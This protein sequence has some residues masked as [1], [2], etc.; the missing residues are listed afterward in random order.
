[1]IR[2]WRGVGA[3]GVTLALLVAAGCGGSSPSTPI[4]TVADTGFR[5]PANGLPFQNYGAELSDGASPDQLDRRGRA[6]AVR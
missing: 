6:E 1:M 3:V 2:G 5:P 4:G